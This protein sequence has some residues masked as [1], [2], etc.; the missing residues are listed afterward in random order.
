MNVYV[1][2]TLYINTRKLTQVWY[3]KANNKQPKYPSL[4]NFLKKIFNLFIHKRHR[5]RGR[6]TGRE[7]QALHR[8]PHVGPDTRRTGSRPGPKAAPNR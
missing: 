4:G 2:I 6:D 8:E 5:E 7:K 1:Y 3:I